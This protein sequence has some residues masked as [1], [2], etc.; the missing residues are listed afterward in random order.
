MPSER[1]R[2]AFRVHAAYCFAWALFFEFLPDDL[3]NVLGLDLPQN[4]VSWIATSVAAGGLVTAGVLFWLASRHAQPPRIALGTA[5]IQTGF[6]L[7]HDAVWIM[8]YWDR[9]KLWLVLID[10]VVVASL[11][12]VYLNT[13]RAGRVRR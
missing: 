9:D 12:S 13:W 7:Y 2:A 3:M 4:P 8:A 1:L 10:T 5:L 11:F 6:N